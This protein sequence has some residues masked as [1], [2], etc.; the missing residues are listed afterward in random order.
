MNAVCAAVTG[1]VRSCADAVANEPLVVADGA[2]SGEGELVVTV[3]S[4]DPERRAWLT[5]VTDA[6]V[7]GL[8]R[9]AAEAPAEVELVINRSAQ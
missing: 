7:A 1:I 3:R 8:E 6:L 2:S 4:V 9:M 5:G